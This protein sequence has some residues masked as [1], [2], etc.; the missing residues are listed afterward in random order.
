MHQ[1]YLAASCLSG[2]RASLSCQASRCNVGVVGVMPAVWPRVCVFETRLWV[3][4][5]AGGTVIVVL[6]LGC[7]R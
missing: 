1:G 4:A 5:S 2:P 7:F 6:L 3:A